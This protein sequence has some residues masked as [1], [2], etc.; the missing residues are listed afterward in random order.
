MIKSISIENFKAFGKKQVLPIKPITLIFGPNSSGKSSIIHSLLFS[1]HALKTGELDVFLTFGGGTSVD[2]GGFK[3]YIF[4]GN[5][6]NLLTWSATLQLS[7]D[8]RRLREL[9]SNSDQIEV[10]STIRLPK[11]EIKERVTSYNAKKTEQTIEVPT[12]EYRY[13]ETPVITSYSI[14]IDGKELFSMGFREEKILRIE[15]LNFDHPVLKDLLKNIIEG[16][17]TLQKVQDSDINISEKI[18]R[19]SLTRYRFRCDHFIPNELIKTDEDM[20]KQSFIYPV[21]QGTRDD[22]VGKAIELFLPRIL[23]DIVSGIWNELSQNLTNL[24]YLGP[25]RSYPPRHLAFT[26]SEDH[27]W[28]AGG[29][30]AWDILRKD[31]SVRDKI[32]EWL[33]N[34]DRLKTPYR[35]EIKDFSSL[36]EITSEYHDKIEEFENKF[37]TEEYDWDLFGELYGLKYRMEQWAKNKSII[38]ELYLKDLRTDTA[39]SHRDVGIGISQII[40]VLVSAYANKMKMIAIE[41]PEIHVHPGLQAELG[42]LFIESALGENSNKFILETHSEH[43]ILRILRRIRETSLGKDVSYKIKPS[44]ISLVFIDSTKNGAVIKAL[45]VDEKGRII[46]KVPGGFFEEDFEELF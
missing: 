25:L 7:N 45:R 32:N 39:V 12:G 33:G 30:F 23:N 2:L 16:G 35:L 10:T 22:D 41:Q 11:E 18:I 40:P 46:D 31:Q 15:R 43:I 1:Q 29:G 4:K 24:E 27:N 36:E 17:T 6:D 28:R 34:K 8:Q 13:A 20:K 21:S 5:P 37:T 3:Q 19:K 38:R 9:L 42:D 26:E 14:A 44:D